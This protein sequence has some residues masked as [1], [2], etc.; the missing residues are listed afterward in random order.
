MKTTAKTVMHIIADHM[1]MADCYVTPE[2]KIVADLG[3]DSLDEIE[4]VMA[5]EAHFDLEIDDMDAEKCITVAD[6]IALV[7]RLLPTPACARVG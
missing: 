3:A 5:I 6:C 2:T 7:D 4:M 1:G